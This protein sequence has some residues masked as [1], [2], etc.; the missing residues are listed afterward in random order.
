MGYRYSLLLAVL[1]VQ[2]E[3]GLGLNKAEDLEQHFVGG[4]AV[5][6][7]GFEEGSRDS[8]TNRTLATIRRESQL[9]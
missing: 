1:A 5:A 3:L 2:E 6:L 9:S 8:S 4:L 7:L